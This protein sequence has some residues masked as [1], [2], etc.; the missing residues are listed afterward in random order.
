MYAWG[1]ASHDGGALG[2]VMT[3]PAQMGFSFASGSVAAAAEGR[4]CPVACDALLPSPHLFY[5]CL[6]DDRA[7]HQCYARRVGTTA[8]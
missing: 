6:R 5:W 7:E 3:E 8:R 2:A 4:R 1:V